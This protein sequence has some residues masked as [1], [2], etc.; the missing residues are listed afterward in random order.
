MI[1]RSWYGKSHKIR[2]FFE[3]IFGEKPMMPVQIGPD[4]HL[5]RSHRFFCR[6]VTVAL[7]GSSDLLKELRR[8]FRSWMNSS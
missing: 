3:A 4:L 6:T 2:E 1:L 8:S 5:F 7:K